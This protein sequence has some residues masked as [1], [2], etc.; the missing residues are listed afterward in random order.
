MSL[1]Y[2]LNTLQFIVVICTIILIVKFSII[3]SKIN[4]T[5]PLLVQS[6]EHGVSVKDEDGKRH[7]EKT[8]LDSVFK[9]DPTR[10][11]TVTAEDGKMVQ[12]K[13]GVE[14]D[15]AEAWNKTYPVCV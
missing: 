2:R 6:N 15:P 10:K 8:F 11:I 14:A 4:V 1:L 3:G 9:E 5:H 13:C 12:D 7:H